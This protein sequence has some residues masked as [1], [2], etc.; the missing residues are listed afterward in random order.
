MGLL[1]TFFETERK[2]TKGHLRSVL[3]VANGNAASE[4]MVRMLE[5]YYARDEEQEKY[6][7]SHRPQITLIDTASPS[8][9]RFAE[10]KPTGMEYMTQLGEQEN[11]RIGLQYQDG[12]IFKTNPTG[13]SKDFAEHFTADSRGEAT[14]IL[15]NKRIS[16]YAEKG[17]YDVVLYADTATH[18]AS[19]VLGLTSQ[20]RGFTIPWECGTLVK[21]PNGTNNPSPLFGRLITGVYAARPMKDLSDTEITAYLNITRVTPLEPTQP[22]AQGSDSVA[23]IDQ[24]MVSYISGLE[25]SFPSIVATTGRTADKL[26]FPSVPDGQDACL[27]CSMPKPEGNV[28]SWLDN[29]TVKEAAVE[30]DR[31]EAS[32]REDDV[33][34]DVTKQICY[35]CYTLFRSSRGIVDWPL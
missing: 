27:V 15:W 4:A 32:P 13:E 29:I 5:V 3:I 20:G 17:S 26:D 6:V 21:M 10:W 30:M 31:G 19:K 14:S 25:T 9:S 7:E 23:S 33:G 24:L 2:E 22:P 1:T 35:G 28:K 16:S 8:E 18:I 11:G 12:K 34:E